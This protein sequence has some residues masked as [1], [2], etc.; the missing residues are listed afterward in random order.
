MRRGTR[1]GLITTAVV[2]AVVLVALFM[3]IYNE[4]APPSTNAARSPSASPT[5]TDDGRNPTSSKSGR[6]GGGRAD[7][8]GVSAFPSSL[9]NQLGRVNRAGPPHDVKLVVNSSGSV[10]RIGY[11][12]PT[13]DS[14]PYANIGGPPSPWS[15][16]LTA[17]GNGYLAAI[18][19]Q[20]GGTGAPVTCRIMI[21]GVTKSVRTT[22]GAYG[23]QM[24]L[25]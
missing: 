15:L 20:A 25:A 4:T 1:I 22:Q 10:A 24:C 9:V 16:A 12:V 8:G 3:K 13:A 5:P 21:D 14:S 2:L 19:V 11:L 23:R 6:G 17:H 7:T 18:F